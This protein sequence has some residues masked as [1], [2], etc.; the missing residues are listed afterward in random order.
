MV[1]GVFRVV[2]PFL[3]LNSTSFIIAQDIHICAVC[4][5]WHWLTVSQHSRGGR[6]GDQKFKAIHSYIVHP[7][8]QEILSKKKKQTKTKTKTNNKENSCFPEKKQRTENHYCTLSASES[9][10]P[11]P[12]KLSFLLVCLFICLFFK[13][14]FL[15]VALVVLELTL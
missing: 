9:P 6:L 8:L 7:G 1:L 14:W 4:Q 5:G 3:L 2:Q 11:G 13:T 12:W 10:T 15:C